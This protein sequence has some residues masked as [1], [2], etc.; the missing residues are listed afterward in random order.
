MKNDYSS[1]FGKKEEYIVEYN[2]LGKI[3]TS[4]PITAVSEEQVK[5]VFQRNYSSLCNIKRIQTI[6]QQI[7]EIA[8][9]RA[10]AVFK[11]RI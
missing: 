4:M 9:R 10:N 11:K 2:Y 7:Q 6:D 3:N 5:Q 1:G 8:E